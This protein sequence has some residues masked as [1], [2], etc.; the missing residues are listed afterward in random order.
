MLNSFFKQ[1]AT[2]AQTGEE[3]HFIQV[4]KLRSCQEIS[5][6]QRFAKEVSKWKFLALLTLVLFAC[7]ENDDTPSADSDGN[8]APKKKTEERISKIEISQFGKITQLFLNYEKD[9]VNI[10]FHPYNGNMDARIEFNDQKQIREIISGANRIQYL[11][12]DKH[13]EIGIF[14]NDGAQQLMFE[15]DGENISHQYTVNGR[16]TVVKFR[17]QYTNGLPSVVEIVGAYP[18]YRKYTLEYSDIPNALTGFNELILPPELINLLGLPA[19]YGKKYLKRAVRVDD[20]VS[21]TAPLEETYTPAMKEVTFD[22]AK[23]DTQETLTLTSD[24][25]RQWATVIYW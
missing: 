8:N 13:R 23:T 18:Y 7:G 12:D 14:T 15:Y 16:D 3:M 10:E 4:P 19:L 1:N 2:N 17:Y 25:T 21:S 22:I 24:G 6:I 20:G 11:Y 5:G 9:V